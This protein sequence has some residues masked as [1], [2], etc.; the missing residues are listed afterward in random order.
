MNV[1]LADTDRTRRIAA[2]FSRL[3]AEG[4]GALIPFVE[5]YDPDRAT[6]LEIL[7]GLPAAGADL[8]EIGVPFTDPAAD[9]PIIQAAGQRA[10]AAGGSLHGTLGMVRSFRDDDDDDDTPIV[11]MGYLNPILSYHPERFCRDAAAAGVDGVIVVDM[12]AEEHDELLPAVS[13]NGLEL[14]RLV[15]PTTDDTRLSLVLAGATGFIYY[16]SVTGITGTRSATIADLNSAIPRIR[17]HT[18]LP[19]AIGFGLRTPEQAAAAVEIA[20]AAVVGSA[21]MNT[22]AASL[23]GEGCAQPNTVNDVLSQVRDLAAA[24]RKLGSV[25]P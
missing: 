16:V 6:S 7:R 5:A 14:I 15:A 12:P 13:S 24:V 17:A 11:L 1:G 22:L 21:L 2:R 25:R 20:D 18:D 10:L 23:D 8:I 3:R 9:G 4:R 19:I